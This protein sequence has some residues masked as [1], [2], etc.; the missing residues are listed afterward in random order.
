MCVAVVTAVDNTTKADATDTSSFVNVIRFN[1]GPIAVCYRQ[2]RWEIG[3][4]AD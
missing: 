2:R 1:Y 3:D 4:N